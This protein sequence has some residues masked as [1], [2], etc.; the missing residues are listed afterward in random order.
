MPKTILP[1]TTTSCFSPAFWVAIFFVSLL[2]RVRPRPLFVSHSFSFPIP[3]SSTPCVSRPYQS[4]FNFTCIPLR[5]YSFHI[6]STHY[7]SHS[8]CLP[9]PTCVFPSLSLPLPMFHY[10]YLLSPIHLHESTTHFLSVSLAT[11]MFHSLL[12]T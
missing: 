9:L 11:S 7:M 2:L 12:Y 4:V 6:Y 3:S 1:R 8:L 10:L 5:M